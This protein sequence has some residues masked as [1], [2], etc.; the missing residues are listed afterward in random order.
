M[1]SPLGGSCVCFLAHAARTGAARPPQANYQRLMS[2]PKPPAS[3]EYVTMIESQSAGKNDSPMQWG[4]PPRP[5]HTSPGHLRLKRPHPL[6]PAPRHKP[7][8]ATA[9]TRFCSGPTRRTVTA[10]QEDIVMSSVN[11]HTKLLSSKE[12]QTIHSSQVRLLPA[13]TPRSRPSSILTRS[14]FPSHVCARKSKREERA[15]AR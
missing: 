9:T 7:V 14:P 12:G 1:Q 4:F 11:A 13:T 5:T 8:T 2:T 10:P 6:S 3:Y 15:T